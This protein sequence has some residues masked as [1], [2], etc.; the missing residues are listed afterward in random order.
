MNPNRRKSE[1]GQSLV[2]IALG[3][4][5]FIAILALVIDGA[6]AYAAKRQAQNAA[7]AGALAGATY[8]C[9]YHDVAGGISTAETYAVKNGAV[10]PPEVTASM[11]SATMIVTATVTRTTFFAGVIGYEQV[12]PVAVAEAACKTPVGMGVLPVAWSCRA[13]AGNLP[14]DACVQK[15]IDDCGGLPYGPEDMGCTYVLMDSVK[16][17]GNGNGNNSCDPTITD[18]N[19]PKYCYEQNDLECATQLGTAP[20]CYPDPTQMSDPNNSK[21][22]CDLDNDCVDELMTGGARSWLDLNG[23]GG[24][25]AELTNWIKNGFPDPI[26][27]HKWLPNESGV[28]TSIFHTAGNYV[29]GEDVILPVYNKVCMGI[30]PGPPTSPE[31]LDQCNTGTVDDTSLA[32]NGQNNY[33]II[34]FSEFHV[35]CVQTTKNKVIAEPGYQFN[36]AKKNCNGHEAAVNVGAIDDNDKTIEGYFKVNDL[37]G[38]GGPG[39]WFDTGTFTVVLVR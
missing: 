7:D 23:G 29:V 19:D 36:N 27:P 11:S 6:N 5:A 15:T 2:I 34:T 8:M 32:V 35:T 13:N 17:K 21:I 10:N 38:Y 24:G 20:N 26:P 33:H 37:G 3:I 9:Q 22:D 39:S 12:S 28:A 30:P 25:A 16:V 1:S 4:I 31:T 14:G 18:P